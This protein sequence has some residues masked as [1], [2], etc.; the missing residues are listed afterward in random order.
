MRESHRD[1]IL[2]SLAVAP[3]R[4]SVRDDLAMLWFS[5]DMLL[6]WSND[7][8]QYIVALGWYI[9]LD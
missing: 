6:R 5:I 3:K 2:K 7:L 4:S 1:C 9:F 8:D